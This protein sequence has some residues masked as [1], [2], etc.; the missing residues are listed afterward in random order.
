M[1]RLT[2]RYTHAAVSSNLKN[3]AYHL[4]TDLLAAMKLAGG[5]AGSMAR[6][7]Y[8]H[9]AAAYKALLAAW[10]GMVIYKAAVRQWKGDWSPK[11]VAKIS[12]DYWLDD[13]CDACNGVGF[14]LMVGIATRSTKVCP[15][16][17]GSKLNPLRCDRRL[18]EPALDMYEALCDVFDKARIRA[19]KKL[20]KD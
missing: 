10:T 20:G 9:D 16:C 7:K 3:D 14:P 19:S 13:Q 8:L 17:D 4:D 15:A 5:L 1:A 12:L 11:A 2:E 6:V 18:R